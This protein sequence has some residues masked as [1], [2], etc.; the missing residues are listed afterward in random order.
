MLTYIILAIGFMIIIHNMDFSRNWSDDG[1]A[2]LSMFL[3]LVV[4]T[5]IIVIVGTTP[6]SR[7]TQEKVLYSI[8]DFDNTR[9]YIGTDSDYI[10][11]V[12][13]GPGMVKYRMPERSILVQDESLIDTGL[14][15]EHKCKPG[16]SPSVVFF[17]YRTDRMHCD[18]EDKVYRR[19]RDIIRVPK[20]TIKLN[21]RESL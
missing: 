17:V 2:G 19:Q 3:S 20:G 16:T 9:W 5:V 13:E 6:S 4:S 10:S 8:K 7:Y 11:Y 1:K 18:E 12:K 14:H 15:I 21:F